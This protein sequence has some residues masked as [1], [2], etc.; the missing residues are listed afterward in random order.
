MRDISAGQSAF[1]LKEK[2]KAAFF[3]GSL[4]LA[5]ALEIACREKIIV[6][7]FKAPVAQGLYGLRHQASAPVVLVQI[8]AQFPAL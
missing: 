5:V 4:R 2:R 6:P 8:K 3:N 1:I 7:G